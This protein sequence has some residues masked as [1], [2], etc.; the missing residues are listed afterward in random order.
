MVLNSGN[1]GVPNPGNRL[2]LKRGNPA[3]KPIRAVKSSA[4]V[5]LLRQ[6][7]RYTDAGFRAAI[8]AIAPG[9]TN[10]QIEGAAV[11]ATMRTGADS[12]GMW[13]R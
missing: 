12:P 11:E 9:R 8:A 4:E 2:V 10:R 6:A 5:A 7:A 13:R 3:I 1:P